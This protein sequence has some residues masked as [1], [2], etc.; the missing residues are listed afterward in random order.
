[1]AWTV[2]RSR[3]TQII[4][5]YRKS[6]VPLHAARV[7]KGL[8]S[9]VCVP[10]I[11]ED[12]CLGVLN[13][14]SDRAHAFTVDHVA[15]IEDL[16]PHLAV[17]IEKTR[18]FEQA[19]ARALRMTRLAE[20]SRLVS[21]TLDVQ[22]VQQFVTSVAADLL[23]ADLTRLF[24]LDEDGETIRLAAAT[25]PEDPGPELIHLTPVPQ[26]SVHDTIIGHAMLSQ[27]PRV[28]PDIT[29]DPLV[30]HRSWALSRG[31]RSQILVPLIVENRSI[32]ALDVTY[33]SRRMHSTDDVE[34][35]EL[36]AA[37]AANAI[38]NARLYDQAIESSRLKSEFVANMSH[39]IRTPMNGVIGMTGL[40]L[41]TAP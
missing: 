18:L 35:L 10:I 23:G 38:R 32:G 1:M 26:F 2:I 21:E 8:L 29:V 36:L 34:L 9:S 33:R 15:Y 39:E 4:G 16:T 37:Q 11:R 7:E 22:R 30:K 40:L 13:L 25:S 31:F 6:T 41:D 24:L 17:A 5:D 20:L 3:H 14:V 19:T 12:E 27:Q 28:T